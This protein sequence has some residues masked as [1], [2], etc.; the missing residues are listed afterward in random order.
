MKKMVAF[1]LV[2][3]VLLMGITAFA[4]VPSKT[5]SDIS[6][7]VNRASVTKV[8]LSN[9]FTIEIVDDTE[10]AVA[11]F[12]KIYNHAVAQGK[13]PVIYFSEELQSQVAEKLS[14]D[15]DLST[16]ELNEFVSIKAKGYQESFGDI[17]AALKFATKYELNQDIVVLLGL[18][19]GQKD[20]SGNYNVS[21]TVVEAQAQEDGQL[22]ILF[23]QGVMVSLQNAN[24]AALAVLN[25]P[26]QLG[27]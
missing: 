18:F 5:T 1:W 24:A 7:V 9:D 13:A 22:K 6:Q 27:Q 15:F 2:V 10:L 25:G 14:P 4:A 17:E 26:F 12:D 8:A 20:A 19:D 21:W 11:E 16:L 3:T 23:P